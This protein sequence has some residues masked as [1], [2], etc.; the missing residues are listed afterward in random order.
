MCN[1]NAHVRR[2][3]VVTALAALG[4][5]CPSFAAAQ[6]GEHT[7]HA[8]HDGAAP[9]Y[10]APPVTEADRAAAFPDLGSGHAEHA[11]LDDPL[12]KLVLLERLETQHV[13]GGDLRRWDVSSWIGKSLTKLWIRTEGEARRERLVRRFISPAAAGHHAGTAVVAG[14]TTY[15]ELEALWGKGFARWWELL[16]GARADFGPSP[17]QNWAAVGV[18]GTTPF[19]IDLEATAYVGDGGR[20]ALRMKAH[21]ELLVTNRLILQPLVELNWYAQKDAARGV[22]S[23]LAD[24]EIGLR[25][26]YEVKREVAPYLG[27]VTQRTL[28][29]TANFA[30]AAGRAASDTRF[31]AGIRL[32]F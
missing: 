30:R 23:G 12:N 27:L 20:A 29:N 24:A 3:Y 9:S 21:Y 17:T 13:N 10:E 31:V 14:A 22:G 7:D 32:R 18:R 4:L 11:M 16:A 19:R 8:S 15:T 5:A 25:L 6:H 28:G 26:R 1:H 2:A